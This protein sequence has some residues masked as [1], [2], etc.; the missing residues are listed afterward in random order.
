MWVI[1]SAL[2]IIFHHCMARASCVN[3]LLFS[4]NPLVTSYFSQLNFHAWSNYERVC[5]IGQA[6]NEMVWALDETL[7]TNSSSKPLELVG[8]SSCVKRVLHFVLIF[9]FKLHFGAPWFSFNSKQIIQDSSH[10][11]IGYKHLKILIFE[12]GTLAWG[13]YALK[14]VGLTRVPFSLNFEWYVVRC[15]C[16]NGYQ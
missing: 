8:L 13:D 7:L 14:Y 10:P 4:T 9:E 16:K 3:T 11:D 6:L 2:G 1:K 12:F 15:A 5:R